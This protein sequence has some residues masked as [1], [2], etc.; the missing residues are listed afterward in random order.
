MGPCSRMKVRTYPY[1]TAMEDPAG[2]VASAVTSGSLVLLTLVGERVVTFSPLFRFQTVTL[3]A[4]AL[5]TE[6]TLPSRRIVSKPKE[7]QRGVIWKTIMAKLNYTNL[8]WQMKSLQM[9][10]QVQNEGTALLSPF[11]TLSAT[12]SR[13][14]LFNKDGSP[15]W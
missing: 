6:D 7:D 4:V 10:V 9:M 11:D 12:I 15:F 14:K 5:A 8:L 13:L 1:P 2:S 3:S